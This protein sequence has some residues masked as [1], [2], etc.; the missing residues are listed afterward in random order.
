LWR[1]F[2][3]AL[4]LSGVDDRTEKRGVVKAYGAGSAAE[5]GV[6][7]ILPSER[8]MSHKRKKK[9]KKKKNRSCLIGEREDVSYDEYS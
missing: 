8:R 6:S 2:F 1:V 3:S 5:N 9:K 4:Q 7:K